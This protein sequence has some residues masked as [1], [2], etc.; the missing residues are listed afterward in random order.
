MSEVFVFSSPISVQDV[1]LIKKESKVNRGRSVV[2]VIG[3]RE[4][5]APVSNVNCIGFQLST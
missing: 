1:L 5:A 4:D 2:E 3:G